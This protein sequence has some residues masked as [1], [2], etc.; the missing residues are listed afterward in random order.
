VAANLRVSRVGLPLTPVT[1]TR[2]DRRESGRLGERATAALAPGQADGG[3]G[4]RTGGWARPRSWRHR[5]L[6]RRHEPSVCRN[7]GMA[8]P[9]P[10][11]W[12]KKTAG[13]PRVV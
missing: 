10:G 1:A 8:R 9:A 6:G 7:E 13:L 5:R 4:Y 3:R 12:V 2:A 11:R